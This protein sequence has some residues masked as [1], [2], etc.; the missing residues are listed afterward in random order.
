MG[1]LCQRHAGFLAGQAAYL[2]KH[3]E[4]AIWNDSSSEA[5]C[6]HRNASLGYCIRITYRAWKCFRH[7][8]HVSRIGF[9]AS[10]PM[11]ITRPMGAHHLC[12]Y[13]PCSLGIC[14][15]SLLQASCFVLCIICSIII[16]FQ[17]IKKKLWPWVILSSLFI[18]NFLRPFSY[19][20]NSYLKFCCAEQEFNPFMF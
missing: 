11:S 4:R 18:F 10:V 9:I 14:V 16:W 5:N 8:V 15:F 19:L 13:Q 20:S 6:A 7:P 3:D 17:L 12:E 2:L 1:L